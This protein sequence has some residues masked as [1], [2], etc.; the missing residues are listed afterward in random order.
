MNHGGGNP[1]SSFVYTHVVQNDQEH[2]VNKRGIL[3]KWLGRPKAE[4]E[5]RIP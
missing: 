5:D 4:A 2:H 3:Y 1:A